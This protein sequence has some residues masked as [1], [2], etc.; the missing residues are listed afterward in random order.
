MEALGA[1]DRRLPLEARQQRAPWFLGGVRG[2]R[3]QPGV[4]LPARDLDDGG[5]C[6]AYARVSEDQRHRVALDVHGA[7]RSATKTLLEDVS[8]GESTFRAGHTVSA[9]TRLDIVMASYAHSLVL[10]DLIDLA[11]SGGVYTMPLRFRFEGA[12]R[13]EAHDFT[14]PLPVVGLQFDFAVTPSV[15]L[16]QRLGLFYLAYGDFKGSLGSATVAVEWFPW[17]LVGL[18]LGYASTSL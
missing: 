8:V 13:R 5:A 16:R 6:G 4:A 2:A 17:P 9:E 12:S 10:D 3:A 14:A 18:A 1:S 11:L 7:S 15:F